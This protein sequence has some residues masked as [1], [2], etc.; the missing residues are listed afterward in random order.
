MFSYTF[1]SGIRSRRLATLLSGMLATLAPAQTTPASENESKEKVYELS[2]FVVT[3][4]DDVGYAANSTLAGSRLKSDLKDVAAPISVF[5]KELL[6][7]IG[8]TTV[9]AALEY[10]LNSVTEYDV[11]GNGIVS[12]NFQSRIRGIAGAGRS[13]NYISTNLNVDLYN[14]ERLDF[15]RGPNSVLFGIGSPAGIIDSSTKFARIGRDARSVQLRFGSYN[16]KRASLDL[17]ESLSDKIAVRA[18]LLWQKSDGYREFEFQDK[19]G[20]A[21]AVTWRPFQGTTVRLEGERLNVEENR[22]RPWTPFD[23]YIGWEQAGSLG[24]NT[25]TAWSGQVTGTGTP[26]SNAIV[27]MDSGLWQDQ[28]V[29]N[30][31]SQNFKWSNGA[32]PNIPGLN[33]PPNVLDFTRIPRDANIFGAGARSSSNAKVGGI[34]VEQKVNE[35]LSLEFAYATE[36]E[37]RPVVSPMN[38]GN[39]RLRYDTNAFLPV[40]NS[41]GVQTGM[42]QNPGFGAPVMITNGGFGSNSHVWSSNYRT[43]LRATGAYHLDLR[44]RFDRGS[45]L[46]RALGHH[47]IAVLLSDV[48]AERTARNSRWVNSDATRPV[49]NYFDNAN[50]IMWGS[51]YDPFDPDHGRRGLQDPFAR[52]EQTGRTPLANRA[53]VFVTPTLEN[54]AWTWSRTETLT[55]M[56]ATQS[57]LWDDRVVALF[58]WRSDKQDIFDSTSTV[59]AGSGAVRGFTRNGKLRAISGNTFT[60]GIVVHVI[61]ELFSVYYNRAN[62]FQDNDVAEIIGPVG[63]LVSI[64]NRS[65]EGQDIGVKLSLFQG[66]LNASLGWYETADTNQNTAIDGGVFTYTEAMWTALG[67]PVDVGGRDTRSLKSDGFEF[68]LTANPTRQITLTFNAKDAATTVDNLYPWAK[69][70]LEENRATWQAGANIP[71]PQ[72]GPIPAGAT[73]GTVLQQLESLLQTL[74]APEGR[75]PFADRERTANFFGR[76]SFKDDGPMKG[77]AFGLGLQYRGKSLIAYRTLTDNAAVYSP[78]YTM[79]NAMISYSRQLGSKMDLRLQLNVDNLFDLQDPQPVSGGEPTADQL[80]T[81]E[82]LGALQDGVVYTV[83]L[84]VPRRYSITATLSF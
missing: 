71:V 79:A 67:T 21:G 58:G 38:F 70:Y 51:Y 54:S 11:T 83:Q 48:G 40:F 62:N 64:G 57:Y 15:S 25:A 82:A 47:R 77:F 76:Y 52:L 23:G 29:W 6:E 63:N 50:R 35:D 16:E 24:N 69:R 1:M 75:A 27:F 18:N 73:V 68:E 56:I 30:S 2:P 37:E 36:Y 60:R 45:T 13:R 3:S 65:G 49:A 43:E 19:Q 7:D 80:A 12:N 81:Y 10:G 53:G 84:P 42:Q 28:F 17:N 74:T 8:A 22:A 72:S 20:L 34:Y 26:S 46:A 9:N 61:P 14:T 4:D 59:E 39:Y 5:T 31:A 41:A 66:K 55:R 44:K 33:T 78:S 32:T